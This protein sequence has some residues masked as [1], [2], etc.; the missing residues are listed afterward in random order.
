LYDLPTSSELIDA[1]AKFLK[2]EVSP[3]LSGR[4]AFHARVA[5]N[6]L[7]LVKR[8][9]ALGPAATAGEASRLKAL[10]GHDGPLGD[11]EDELCAGIAAG[12]IDPADPALIDH[13]WATTLDTLAVDQPNY[14]TYRRAAAEFAKA[15]DPDNQKT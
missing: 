8:E 1:V 7:D 13:L 14:A 15:S 6:V 3:H 4:V 5:V 9:L 2:D 12:E 11:L 10:L